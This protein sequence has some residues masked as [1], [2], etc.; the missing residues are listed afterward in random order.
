MRKDLLNI[1]LVIEYMSKIW[2]GVKGCKIQF[3]LKKMNSF[4]HGYSLPN[5]GQRKTK[6]LTSSVAPTQKE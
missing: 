1:G 3:S 5:V 4:L 6:I 2:K